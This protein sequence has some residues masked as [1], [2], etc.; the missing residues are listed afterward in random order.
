MK[1][2]RRKFIATSAALAAGTVS[3]S[4]IS[5]NAQKEEW[6]IVHHVFFWLKNPGSVEDRDKLVAGVKTL[7]KIETVRK[8]RV[9]IVASTEKRDVVDNS[10]AV[11]ELMFFSDL[12]GQATYQ[13]H[14]IHL[15]F[16]K[17]CSH[18]W[19]KVIV[20]DAQDV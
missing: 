8:L 6:P 2:T 18:L 16:I 10:W 11:S 5:L 17:N 13:T 3:A 14:P 19:E 9:G 7:A 1:S 4:A 12:A 15:E 20:Y